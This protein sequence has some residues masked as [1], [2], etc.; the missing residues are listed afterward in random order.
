MLCLWIVTFLKN[1]SVAVCGSNLNKNQLLILLHNCKVKNVILAF[2]KEYEKIGTP[3]CEK[4]LNKIRA[5]GE[6]YSKYYQ[7]YYIADREGLLAHKDSPIDKG[8]EIFQRLMEKK[9]VIRG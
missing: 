6:K 8:P 3:E 5:I 9:V 2:D 1:N 4:Y 7:F